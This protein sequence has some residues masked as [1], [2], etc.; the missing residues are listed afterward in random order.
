MHDGSMH[1]FS[2]GKSLALADVDNLYNHLGCNK[3]SRPY[4]LIEAKSGIYPFEILYV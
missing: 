1:V 3:K 4:E 2:H